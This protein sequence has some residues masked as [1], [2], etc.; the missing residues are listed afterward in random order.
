[1]APT[2]VDTVTG[3]NIEDEIYVSTVIDNAKDL[4]RQAS[5]LADHKVGRYC[6]M[7]QLQHQD[8]VLAPNHSAL[9]F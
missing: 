6:Q 5:H 4:Y 9:K 8:Y 7:L 2:A 1:M 3:L